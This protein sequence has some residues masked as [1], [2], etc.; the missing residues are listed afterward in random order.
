MITIK[1]LENTIHN[2]SCLELMK[3][4]PDNTIDLVITDP[5]YPV[6]KG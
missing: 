1:E 5:P 3:K 4:I 6:I 2:T